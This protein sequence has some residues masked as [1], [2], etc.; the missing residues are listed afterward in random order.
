MKTEIC[1]GS[2]FEILIN[3]T[4]ER[5]SFDFGAGTLGQAIQ[6]AELVFEGH[7]ELLRATAIKEIII[8]DAHTGE[9]LA[10]CAPDLDYEESDFENEDHYT[11]DCDDFDLEMGF[12]PYEGCWTGDC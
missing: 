1:Y 9:I 2:H 8:C 5:F 12:D 7:H 6:W 3:T 11:G 4:N 10:E